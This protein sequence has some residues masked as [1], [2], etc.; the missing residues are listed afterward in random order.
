MPELPEVQTIVNELKKE[1]KSRKITNIWCDWP[2]YFKNQNQE[3]FKKIIKGKKI[4]EIKRIG[5]NILF[6]LSDNLIL[7]IHQKISG[8]LLVGQ[9]QENKNL[10]E[11]P[12][13]WQ[14]EKWVPIKKN[15]P[16]WDPHNRFIHFIIFLDNKK[17]LA[18]SDLR[19]FAK[20]ILG[21]KDE[22]LK[23]KDL[24]VGQDALEITEEEF[25][26]ILNK[27]KGIIKKILMDQKVIAGIGNIYS[28][29]I[30]WLSKIHPLTL[31]SKLTK[32]QK[33]EIFKNIKFVLKKALQLKGTSIDEYRLPS[34]IR[35]KYDLERY[36]YQKENQPCFRC[37]NSIKRIKINNRSSYFCSFCQKI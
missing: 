18:L 23:L 11:I 20:I 28:D 5:K 4:L 1:L 32:K 34:G 33:H 25:L 13:Q 7:L 21:S 12:H 3:N 24:K 17:Q 10:K 22:I 26:K 29:E 30:L 6:F 2:K 14:K 19:K 9:W 15:S 16:L 36:V 27:K 37:K 8:H 35:G 31:V